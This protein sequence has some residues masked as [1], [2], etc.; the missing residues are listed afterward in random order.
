MCI[1]DRS[2]VIQLGNHYEEAI[3]KARRRGQIKTIQGMASPVSYTHLDVYKRQGLR[4]T[5]LIE[6][7]VDPLRLSPVE[8]YLRFI[9]SQDIVS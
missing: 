9:N 8:N 2:L 1:R 7:L 4:V 3:Q 5:S 6:W